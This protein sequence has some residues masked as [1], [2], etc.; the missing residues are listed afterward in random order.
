[1]MKKA[2]INTRHSVDICAKSPTD[3]ANRAVFLRKQATFFLSLEIRYSGSGRNHM[4]YD[5]S[6]HS[7]SDVIQHAV[8]IHTSSVHARAGLILLLESLFQ[9]SCTNGRGPADL[10]CYVGQYLSAP[11]A[12]RTGCC[13]CLPV[14]RE[15][16]VS[17]RVSYNESPACP[18]LSAPSRS[19]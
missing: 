12:R 8:L 16:D 1:M 11:V 15:L 7:F 13:T 3:I 17:A 9:R 4:C 2:T 5:S 14:M 10:S 18:G 19:P 6:T